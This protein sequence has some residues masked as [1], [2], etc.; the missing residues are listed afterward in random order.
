VSLDVVS[1]AGLPAGTAEGLAAALGELQ[2]LKVAVVAGANTNTNI[3]VAGILTE[4]TVVNVVEVAS[5]QVHEAVASGAAHAVNISVPGI[6]VGDIIVSV[7][8]FASGVPTDRTSEASVT[9]AG[10]IQLSTTDTTGDKLVVTYYHLTDP[11]EASSKAA[12]ITSNGNIQIASDTR[13]QMLVVIWFDK[14]P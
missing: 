5:R 9:G 1:T 3:A 13:N 14:N 8:D 11:A 7:L 12:T 6:A 2:R 4:D 10:T